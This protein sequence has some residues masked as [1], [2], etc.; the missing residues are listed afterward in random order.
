MENKQQV[1]TTVTRTFF[2]KQKGTESYEN[3][4]AEFLQWESDMVKTI[5]RME[6]GRVDTQ[7]G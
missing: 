2:S 1:R 7:L 4:V 5:Q 6:V 3:Y